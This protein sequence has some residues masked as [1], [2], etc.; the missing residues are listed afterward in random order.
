MQAKRRIREHC[1]LPNAKNPSPWRVYLPLGG[2]IKISGRMNDIT[3][4]RMHSHHLLTRNLANNTSRVSASDED[5]YSSGKDSKGIKLEH[6][7]MTRSFR[8]IRTLLHR[9]VKIPQSK[10]RIETCQLVRSVQFA[11]CGS[12]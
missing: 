6:P 4:F 7:K 3:V 9:R 1:S 12:E 11:Q 8:S 5:A 10:R 2:K